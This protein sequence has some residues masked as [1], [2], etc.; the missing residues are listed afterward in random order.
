MTRFA[1]LLTF[2]LSG[3][4]TPTGSCWREGEMF[5]SVNITEGTCGKGGNFVAEDVS[6]A[7]RRCQSKGYTEPTIPPHE[8]AEALKRGD[9]VNFKMPAGQRIKGKDE[10]AALADER[11]KIEAEL[12]KAQNQQ[13]PP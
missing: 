9:I 10:E 11:Q 8:M 5:C 1:V 12:Q 7:T 3:C 6:A 2:V 13:P 4:S